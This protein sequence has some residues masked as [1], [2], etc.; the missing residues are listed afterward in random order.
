MWKMCVCKVCLRARARSL[1]QSWDSATPRTAARRAPLSAGLCKAGI[2]EKAAISSPGIF[3]A[4]VR[5]APPASPAP[6]GGVS[7]TET[8][9]K[10]ARNV[11][12]MSTDIPCLGGPSAPG[13]VAPTH[14]ASACP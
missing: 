10:R 12:K 1:A 8:P 13:D 6:A 14:A 2:L 11:G 4:Q 3:L 5:Q 7:I 9:G